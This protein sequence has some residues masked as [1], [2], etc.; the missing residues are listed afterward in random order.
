MD[1]S[2][3]DYLSFN[4]QFYPRYSLAREAQLLKALRIQP[5]WRIGSLSAGQS[6]RVQ[7]VAAFAQE[8]KV[9][10]IDEITAVLDIVGR[11]KFM[12]AVEDL[13]VK[14]GTTVIVATNILDDVD[15]YATH[16]ILLHS[17]KLAKIGTRA[18][19]LASTGVATLAGALAQ[20]I[21]SAEGAE[22]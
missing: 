2:I 21:E 4:R 15:S 10:I 12:A 22:A 13:R 6:R 18:D 20:L 11:H 19:F 17:G 14:V 16:V 8:P 5:S 1:W 3:Q 7:V 9:L